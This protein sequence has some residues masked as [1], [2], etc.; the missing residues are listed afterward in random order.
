VTMVQGG[1]PTGPARPNGR[2]YRLIHRPVAA[3][4]ILICL[5]GSPS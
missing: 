1:E 2:G 3:L 4:Y 5:A